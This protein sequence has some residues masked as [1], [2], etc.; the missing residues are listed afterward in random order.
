MVC[1]TNPYI[2]RAVVF[3]TFLSAATVRKSRNRRRLRVSGASRVLRDREVERADLAGVGDGEDSV[4][5]RGRCDQG[6][7]RVRSAAAVVIG[8]DL[9]AGR[10]EEL[11]EGVKRI[12]IELD[13]V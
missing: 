5:S 3:A 4:V 7:A 1:A 10:P 13:H 2:I 8:G 12:A 6:N 11:E 9:R